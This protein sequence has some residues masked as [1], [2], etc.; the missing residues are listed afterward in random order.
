M[1]F[2]SD[3]SRKCPSCRKWVAYKHRVCPFCQRSLR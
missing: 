3:K 1:F 2:N